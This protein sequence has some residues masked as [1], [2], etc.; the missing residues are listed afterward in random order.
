MI[1]INA[2]MD[3]EKCGVT[4]DVVLNAWQFVSLSNES[5]DFDIRAFKLV[6][7]EEWGAIWQKNNGNGWHYG[8]FC[9][10]CYKE[11]LAS[12]PKKSFFKRLLG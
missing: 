12:I 5:Y 11:K 6:G 4:F 7:F 2:V 1:K 8:T 10:A 9:E 3:C